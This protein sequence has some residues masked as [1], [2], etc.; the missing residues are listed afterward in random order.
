[1]VETQTKTQNTFWLWN[2]DIDLVKR[3]DV[4]Y[5]LLE[6][7]TY[8]ESDKTISDF[9]DLISG[10]AF[11]SEWFQEQG[12]VPVIKM[13]QIVGDGSLDLTRAEYLSK[14]YLDKY[15]KFVVRKGDVLVALTG[16]TIGKSGYYYEDRPSL[17][18]QRVLLLR[19]K[20][21]YSNEFLLAFCLT[22][23]F[24]NNV[25]KESGGG[26]R[27]NISP[28]SVGSIK[29]LQ[30]TKSSRQKVEQIVKEAFQLKK[31]AE[32]DYQKSQQ[33]LND[34][35]GLTGI[36]KKR[37]LT[38]WRW[39]DEIDIVEKLHPLA[40]K[41]LEIKE[42]KDFIKIK[43]FAESL[44]YG[45][46][47]DLTYQ[48]SGVPFLRITD[49]D[50]HFQIDK[51]NLKYISQF[52]VERLVKY[53]VSSEDLLISRT[54]TLGSAILIDAA[55]KNSIFG[56]YFIR[57][58]FN[59]EV[60]TK[61][62]LDYLAFFINSDVGK[63]QSAS[64]SSGGVQTNLTISAIENMEIPVIDRTIQAEIT[65]YVQSF[66]TKKLLSKQKLQEAK[67]F[68]ENLIRSQKQK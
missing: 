5:L 1:M 31:E 7:L 55:L 14:D 26:A 23:Y 47:E 12:E 38:F 25:I 3:L 39:S 44:D 37:E 48:N 15:S 20:D 24:V 19:S 53:R 63:E 21:N 40:Y 2:T 35:L 51:E 33:L 50:E 10:Y 43:D 42:V 9:F 18:N 54:G 66:K 52:D 6:K 68:V 65:K 16:A 67:E 46:S 36:E 34:A 17:L 28:F 49:I 45:T 61:V 58:K 56:S 57:V 29:F 27:A 60:K 4:Q 8:L 11:N 64:L 62:I 59:K 22:D 13:T 41:R 30:T 32:A